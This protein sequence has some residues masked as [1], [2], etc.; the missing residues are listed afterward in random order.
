MQD[1]HERERK[2]KLDQ[3]DPVDI[4]GDDSKYVDMELAN[5]STAEPR[6]KHISLRERIGS[7]K[8]RNKDD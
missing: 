4:A 8:Q 3:R 7:L 6:H 1:Y 5:A 2:G